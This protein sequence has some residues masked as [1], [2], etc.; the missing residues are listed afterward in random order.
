MCTGWQIDCVCVWVRVTV[1][2]VPVATSAPTADRNRQSSYYLSCDIRA[3]RRQQYSLALH[4][5]TL[6]WYKKSK[7]TIK[8]PGQ[9]RKREKRG[10]AKR[11]IHFTYLFPLEETRQL[12]SRDCSLHFLGSLPVRP[13]SSRGLRQRFLLSRVLGPYQ[14]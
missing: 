3:G 13:L 12:S 5:G 2:H 14:I 9:S 7:Q 10:G 1:D 6:R 4:H 11:T 8:Y